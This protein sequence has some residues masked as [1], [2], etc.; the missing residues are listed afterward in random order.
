MFW[1]F[2]L[3]FVVDI[4]AILGFVTVLAT[5]SKIWA[6]LPIFWSP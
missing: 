6:F 5:F 3:S 1:T 2:T 4:L